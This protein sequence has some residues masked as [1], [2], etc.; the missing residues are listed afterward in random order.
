MDS[1]N[2]REIDLMIQINLRPSYNT[3]YVLCTVY[4]H[5]SLLFT[6]ECEA[7]FV[8]AAMYSHRTLFSLRRLNMSFT[9]FG[10]T[11]A[12]ITTFTSFATP[13]VP[14]AALSNYSINVYSKST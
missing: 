2:H 5:Q 6:C 4:T 3:T 10:K 7:C 9:W 14:K 11:P 1:K 12:P 8:S 13:S